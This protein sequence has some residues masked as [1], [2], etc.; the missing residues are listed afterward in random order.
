M[1]TYRPK[2]KQELIRR[3][4]DAGFS[5]DNNVLEK[6]YGSRDITVTLHKTRMQVLEREYPLKE[7]WMMY[8]LPYT[9]ESIEALSK[10]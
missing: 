4:V 2:V 3:L 6:R 5:F 8:S 9:Y 7:G 10:M 1:N